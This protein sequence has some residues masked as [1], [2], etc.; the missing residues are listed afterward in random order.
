M[1]E[2]FPWLGDAGELIGDHVA[3]TTRF[4]MDEGCPQCFAALEAALE[5]RPGTAGRARH[6]GHADRR[7][8]V[9]GEQDAGRIEDLLGGEGGSLGT[10]PLGAGHPEASTEN[11]SDR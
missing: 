9:F 10:Q 8:A 5:R 7:D 11:G 2:S 4:A 3:D 6:V 1:D